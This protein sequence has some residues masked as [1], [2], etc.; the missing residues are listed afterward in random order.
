MIDRVEAAPGSITLLW[1]P[2]PPN[3]NTTTGSCKVA[4]NGNIVLTTKEKI[5]DEDIIFNSD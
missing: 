2:H 3:Q 1:H 5:S 4:Y